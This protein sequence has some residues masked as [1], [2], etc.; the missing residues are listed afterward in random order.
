[1]KSL[2]I[3]I[4]LWFISG[5]NSA[6]AQFPNFPDSN[7]FWRMDVM[8]QPGLIYQFGY[9]LK[10]ENNDTL[11]N[12]IW[13]NSLWNG[14]EGEGGSFAGGFRENEVGQVFYYH[15]NSNTEYLLY[16][17]NV[18][19]GDTVEVFTGDP[20]SNVIL[21]VL[22][23]V[24]VT[25][26]V[27]NNGTPYRQIG[28]LP[29]WAI[30]PGAGDSDEHWIE[31][32]GGTSGL[33]GTTGLLS[34]SPN[35]YMGCMEHNDTLWPWG[36]PGSCN[37]TLGIHD[38]RDRFSSAASP[39]PSTGLFHLSQAPKQITVYNAQGKQLF[40]QHGNEVDLSA[41]PPGVYTAVV[42]TK[43]GPS[44]QRLVVVR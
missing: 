3:L 13:Y 27:N 4:F 25:V 29:L 33:F 23:I 38:V 30:S 32:V 40:R 21:E 42:E 7:A 16:D 28:I 22:R 12:G 9:H 2:A 35:T 39:N 31:G 37:W 34:L 19:T 44:A 36:G 5:I 18:E 8:D 20:A 11:I 24:S 6:S 14:A 1:M 43:K 10:A 15:P 17:F 41:Y 26:L